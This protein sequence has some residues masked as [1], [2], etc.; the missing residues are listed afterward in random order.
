M[1]IL[2][3]LVIVIL[4]ALIILQSQLK[5]SVHNI[6]NINY[7]RVKLLIFTIDLDYMRFM[8]TLKR[9][10]FENDIDLK[11]QINIIKTMN[12]IV[13]DI[14]KQTVIEK[15]LFYKFFNEYSK[16][17]KIITY[18]LFSSYLNSLLEFNFKMLKSYKYEVLYSNERV[19]VDFSFVCGIRIYNIF[20]AVIKN[21]RV[22]IKYFKRRTVNGS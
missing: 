19:D 20:Y 9:L 1:V 3:V 5:I 12:P 18:Y 14:V 10:G 8:K 7:V 16:T 17:Y 4:I 22:L 6:K 21:I 15:A 2:L 11:V 13:K